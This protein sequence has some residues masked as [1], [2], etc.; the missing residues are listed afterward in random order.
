MAWRPSDS[1]AW[2]A[3]ALLAAVPSFKKAPEPVILI[4]AK[5]VIYTL[6]DTQTHKS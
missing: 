3:C 4:L 1:T 5:K 2:E 6:K